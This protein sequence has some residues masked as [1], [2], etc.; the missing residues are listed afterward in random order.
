M[1]PITKILNYYR[2]RRYYIGFLSVEEVKLPIAKRWKSVKWLNEG[3]YRGG[4][5]ADPFFLSVTENRVELLVEEW[6]DA[7]RRGRLAHLDIRR[8]NGEYILEKATP[9]L[10]LEPICHSLIYGEKT[11]RCMFILKI[12]HLVV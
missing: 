12:V 4:W 10:E 2:K 3:N 6:V 8:E 1:N 11:G 5:F 7:Q 9:I